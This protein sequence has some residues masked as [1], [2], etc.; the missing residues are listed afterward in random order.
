VVRLG[1]LIRVDSEDHAGSTVVPLS[2]VHPDGLGVIDGDGEGRG[3]VCGRIDG[4]EARIEALLASGRGERELAARSTERGLGNG[5]VLRDELE[6]DC[7]TG[8]GSDSRRIVGKGTIFADF[9]AVLDA[10]NG[11]GSWVGRVGV[12]LIDGSPSLVVESNRIGHRRMPD[13]SIGL[14]AVDLRSGG[15]GPRRLSGGLSLFL[16]TKGQCSLL[17]GVEGVIPEKGQLTEKTIPCPQCPFCLQYNQTGVV[18]F[19]V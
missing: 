15:S 9:D 12:R 10:L 11:G 4:H 17:E 14:I 18:S 3:S 6:N 7:V 1:A 2:A 16:G 19:T 13:R 5:V 8:V